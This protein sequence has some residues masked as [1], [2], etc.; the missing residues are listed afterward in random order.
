MHWFGSLMQ[1][2]LSNFAWGHNRL[3]EP[4]LTSAVNLFVQLHLSPPFSLPHF[5]HPEYLSRDRPGHGKSVRSLEVKTSS[6][7]TLHG[8]FKRLKLTKCRSCQVG[9]YALSM[10][11]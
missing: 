7:T 11:N 5:L 8:K 1:R 9:C 6:L 2:D 4:E 3:L 10:G